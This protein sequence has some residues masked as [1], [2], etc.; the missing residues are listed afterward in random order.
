MTIESIWTEYNRGVAPSALAPRTGAAETLFYAAVIAHRAGDWAGAAELAERATGL[1]PDHAVY[2]ETARYLRRGETADVYSSP[3]AFT[4]FAVGG[5]N[6][7]LYRSTHAALRASYAQQRPAR[8]LDLGTGEGHGLL[9]A[10]TAEVGHVTAVEPAEE[11]LAIVTAALTQREIP[12]HG[13]ALT[14]QQFMERTDRG[15]WD[16]VQETFALLAVPR[17]DRAR[18]FRWLRPRVARVAFVEFDVPDLGAGFEPSRFR[19]LVSRYE[20]GIREYDSDRDLVAQGFLVPVLLSALGSADHSTH[21]EQP[22]ARWVEDLTA[23]GFTCAEPKLLCNYWW[24]PAYLLA[25]S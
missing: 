7:E 11:R 3:A 12:H 8:L 2:S 14:V 22:I 16:L 23:A 10:L 25:A 4:A 18:L 17:S 5:G 6:V 15:A 1:A 20:Q 19:D 21:H 13:L 24:A 9:P